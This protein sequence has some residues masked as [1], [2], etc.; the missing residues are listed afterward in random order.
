MRADEE[1][2]AELK[3]KD[4]G[5][6]PLI[7]KKGLLAKEKDGPF[8]AANRTLLSPR[9]KDYRFFTAILNEQAVPYLVDSGVLLGLMREGRLLDQEKDID[10]QM[11]AA[12]ENKLLELLPLFWDQGFQV[13]IWLYRGLACQYRFLKEGQLPVHVM[14]FRQ[15]GDLAW[16]PAGEGIGPPFPRELT[17]YLYHYFVVAR[18]KLRERLIV[19]EV[20]RWPWKARRRMGTWQVPLQYFSKR[21]YHP[22][23]SCY[24]PKDWDHYLI[25]RYGSW[26]IPATKWNIWKDDGALKH[27]KPE[28]LFDLA[29]Y[30]AWSGAALLKAARKKVQES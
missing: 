21:L 23:F 28:K 3:A 6:D 14:L 12:D 25:Y 26:R 19:T 5:N 11:W 17:K 30:P 22:L 7:T 13:T 1:R 15:A 24:I 10:L 2:A 20:T 18:R 8:V 4:P 27:Q 9:T 29:G 16:C